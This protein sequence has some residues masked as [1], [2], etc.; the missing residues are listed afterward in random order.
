MVAALWT[1]AALW[2]TPARATGQ[3]AT[4][5][6]AG[7][8]PEQRLQIHLGSQRISLGLLPVRSLPLSVSPQSIEVGISCGMEEMCGLDPCLCGS[9]VDGWGSCAC[10]GLRRVE[11]G[12]TAT[13]SDRGVARVVKMG[14]TFLVYPTGLGEATITVHGSLPHYADAQSTLLVKV[15]PWA[16]AVLG[17]PAVTIIGL[18]LVGLGLVAR[19]IRFHPGDVGCG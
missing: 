5:S 10:N 14:G 4:G 11:P 12:L 16:L 2:M 7:A 3:V 9:A 1:S 19:R 18:L 17:V 15:T 6:A 13:S 8:A